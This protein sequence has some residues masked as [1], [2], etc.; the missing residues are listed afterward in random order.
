[1]LNYGKLENKLT[2]NKNFNKISPR[3]KTASEICSEQKFVCLET[4]VENCFKSCDI[5]NKHPHV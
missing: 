2:M 1:M 3:I 4:F 5:F